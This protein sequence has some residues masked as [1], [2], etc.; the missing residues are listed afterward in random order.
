MHAASNFIT[1][2]PSRLTRKILAI[3]LVVEFYRLYQN[4]GKEKENRC[5]VFASSTEREIRHFRVVVVQKRRQRKCTKSVMHEQTCCFANLNLLLFSCPRCLR[6]RRC[7]GYLII[8]VNLNKKMTS[9]H[10]VGACCYSH[11]LLNC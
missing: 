8:K 9:I 11:Q 4:S 5:L 3:F 2:I 7:L 1:L 10:G 6:R